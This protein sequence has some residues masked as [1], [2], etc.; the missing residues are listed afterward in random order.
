M[1]FVGV[2]VLLAVWS[3][4]V[5]ARVVDPVLLP[6]PI[7]TF[8]AMWVGMTSGKLGVDFIKTVVRTIYSTAIAAV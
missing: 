2:A 5:W 8:K 3:L 1:P 4:T 7:A 6:S